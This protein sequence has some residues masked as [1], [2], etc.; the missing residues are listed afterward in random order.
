VSGDTGQLFI[1][2]ISVGSRIALVAVGF[3]LIYGVTK[4]LHLAHGAVITLGAYLLW[5]LT[6]SVSLPL[7]LALVL[8]GAAMAVVG[9][10]HE[11]L[12]YRPLRSP[13]GANLMIVVGSLGMG[14]LL[15]NL[16]GV[17]FGY[18]TKSIREST[19]GEASGGVRMGDV[20]L[21]M[22][23][24]VSI[25]VALVLFGA[26]IAYLRWSRRGR[27][28]RAVQANPALA[29]VVGVDTRKVYVFTFALGSVVSVPAA[30]FIGLN[31]GL[32][33]TIGFDA[34]LLGFVVAFAGGVGSLAGTVIASF[35]IGV[36]QSMSLLVIS[37]NWQQTATF[38]VLLLVVILRPQGIL[39]KAEA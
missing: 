39:G 33:T 32:S 16:L 20:V 30:L 34:L 9:G 14:I 21:P 25:V 4:T 36:V 24:L 13:N 38:A 12:L 2:G 1:D 7:A 11:R 10:L 27:Q 35:G 29:R 18:D 37:S 26:L 17:V 19:I 6:A 31:S 22:T 15:Q 28:V 5:W 8:A 3:S 23:D